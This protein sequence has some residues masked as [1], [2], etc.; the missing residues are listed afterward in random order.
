MTAG[1]ALA[2]VQPVTDYEWAAS[3]RYDHGRRTVAEVARQIMGLC[4][5][6]ITHAEK[7]L[8]QLDRASVS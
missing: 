8:A 6:E 7:P 1:N 3:A 2:A 4:V 5:V